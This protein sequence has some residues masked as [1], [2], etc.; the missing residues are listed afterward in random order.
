MRTN[1]SDREGKNRKAI[2]ALVRQGRLQERVQLATVEPFTCI[3]LIDTTESSQLS[4][5]R[6]FDQAVQTISNIQL[7]NQL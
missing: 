2:G 3:G 6:H 5:A 7:V 1:F 4:A